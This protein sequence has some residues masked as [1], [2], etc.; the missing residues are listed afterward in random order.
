MLVVASARGRAESRLWLWLV[1]ASANVAVALALAEEQ[2]DACRSFAQPEHC[3][4]LIAATAAVEQDSLNR[5]QSLTADDSVHAAAERAEALQ[6]HQRSRLLREELEA[7]Y[8]AAEV[9]GWP[10]SEQLETGQIAAADGV[11]NGLGVL[12]GRVELGLVLCCV[13]V[14][15]MSWDKKRSA[16]EENRVQK[17]LELERMLREQQEQLQW[18][19]EGAQSVT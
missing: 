19:Q 15:W 10:G 1:V 11:W 16:A 8:A 17:Q 9:S 2:P 18:R 12:G 4:A 5:W 14:V 6:E 7:A 13:V 3:R